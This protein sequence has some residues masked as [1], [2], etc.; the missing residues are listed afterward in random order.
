[1]HVL[2]NK[3]DATDKS[4]DLVNSK[5]VNWLVYRLNNALKLRLSPA[6]HDLDDF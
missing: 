4:T 1:L 5:R 2:H 6:G 3:L